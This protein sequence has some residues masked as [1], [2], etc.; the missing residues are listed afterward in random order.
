MDRTT[1]E[2]KY[3]EA[4]REANKAVAQPKERAYEESYRKL[5]SKDGKNDILKITKVRERIRRDLENIKFIKD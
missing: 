2:G 5:N 3:K 4:K 1:T